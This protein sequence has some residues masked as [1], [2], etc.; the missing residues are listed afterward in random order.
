MPTFPAYLAFILVALPA[1][2]APADAAPHYG[3]GPQLVSPKSSQPSSIY[4]RGRPSPIPVLGGMQLARLGAQDPAIPRPTYNPRYSRHSRWHSAAAKREVSPVAKTVKLFNVEPVTAP[5]ATSTPTAQATTTQTHN[6]M[7]AATDAPQIPLEPFSVTHFTSARPTETAAWPAGE[8]AQSDAH[9][10]KIAVIG[11]ILGSIIGIVILVTVVK[12]ISNGLK[13]RR[14]PNSLASRR[15]SED[16]RW[17]TKSIRQPSLVATDLEKSEFTEIDLSVTNPP[18]PGIIDP[19]SIARFSPPPTPAPAFSPPPSPVPP[20]PMRYQALLS[21]SINLVRQNADP[22][23]A[24]GTSMA[25]SRTS[26]SEASS[27]KGHKRRSSA[28]GSVAWVQGGPSPR[29]SAVAEGYWDAVDVARPES[30]VT[31][32]SSRT[33]S[34]DVAG[35]KW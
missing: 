6:H 7:P 32:R 24:S 29:T 33:K 34:M 4:R 30:A 5:A 15:G 25:S 23:R 13:R 22:Y 2:L 12:M 28:P 17:D 3:S 10:G 11:S 8:V 21:P 18:P 1:L 31:V 27:A 14:H 20:V 16:I 26:E 19:A 9:H 35:L